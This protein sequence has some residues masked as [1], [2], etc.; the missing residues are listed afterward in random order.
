MN[1]YE[2]PDPRRRAMPH[3]VHSAR[4]VI[5]LLAGLGAVLTAGPLFFRNY[6][7]AG[8]YAFAY[9]FAW[10]LAAVA[11]VF[12]MAGRA[13]QVLAIVLAVIE[14]LACL[15]LAM[16][17]PL[18]GLLSLALTIATVVLLCKRETSAWFVRDRQPGHA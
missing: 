15:S 2:F 17:D 10:L 18:M 16:I 13:I 1:A 6:E 3:S 4:T 9:F 11:L 14:T 7:E 5:W 12:G 8:A